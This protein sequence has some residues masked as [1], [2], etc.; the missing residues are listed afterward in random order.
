MTRAMMTRPKPKVPSARDKRERLQWA[1]E[2]DLWES[3]PASDAVPVIEPATTA[4]GEDELGTDT[5]APAN[6]LH[7]A[8]GGSKDVS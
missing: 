4:P 3:F 6:T 7:P 2:E 8:E 5:S 1:L